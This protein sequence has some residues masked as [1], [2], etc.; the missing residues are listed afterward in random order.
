MYFLHMLQ[1]LIQSLLCTCFIKL[2]VFL[3]EWVDE[4]A[5]SQ[6]LFWENVQKIDDPKLA[7]NLP[8]LLNKA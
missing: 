3:R 2:S 4:A 6:T 7:I 5:C 8:H 1:N